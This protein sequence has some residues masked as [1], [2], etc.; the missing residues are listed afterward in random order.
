MAHGRIEALILLV[1]LAA[2]GV[3]ATAG[4]LDRDGDGVPG[5]ADPDDGD[6]AVGA[7]AD[8][9]CGGEEAGGVAWFADID[10]DGWGDWDLQIEACSPA[11]APVR[12]TDRAGDCDDGDAGIGPHA[13]DLPANGIDEDC[14]GQDAPE[15]MAR[16]R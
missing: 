11:L 12:V 13:V 8:A 4:Q 14:D 2:D 3:V 7:E 15:R 5:V 1:S 16:V 6:P 9:D 10:G